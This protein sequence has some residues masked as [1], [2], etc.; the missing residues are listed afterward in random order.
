MSTTPTPVYAE[1]HQD[2]HPAARP[3]VT[4][5]NVGRWCLSEDECIADHIDFRSY[6][7]GV[8]DAARAFGNDRAALA[9]QA[10]SAAPV[11]P[12]GLRA[13]LKALEAL[14]ESLGSDYHTVEKT[15]Y[16]AGWTDAASF[17]KN[18][19]RA[20]I[21]DALHAE[22][23]RQNCETC[24]GTGEY[25]SH[26]EDCQDDLC[27]LNGDMHSCAGQVV[28]CDCAEEARRAT[29]PAAIP[30]APAEAVAMEVASMSWNGFNLHGDPKSI[31]KARQM[32]HDSEIVPELKERIRE[33]QDT[34]A[35][36]QAEPPA[37]PSAALQLL[38]K[39]RQ[40]DFLS[41]SSRG[42]I[43]AVLAAAPAAQ[44]PTPPVAQGP[45]DDERAE[46]RRSGLAAH[47]LTEADLAPPVAQQVEAPMGAELPLTCSRSNR[48][49]CALFDGGKRPSREWYA[50]KIQETEGLDNALPCGALATP[51]QAGAEAAGGGG[52]PKG[53]LEQA[54]AEVMR[55]AREAAIA[56]AAGKR[57]H[58][59]NW[60]EALAKVAEMEKALQEAKALA[61]SEG[62]RAVKYLRV[63]RKVRAV[64]NE[65]P[66]VD[67]PGSPLSRI[68]TIVAFAGGDSALGVGGRE[69][70]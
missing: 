51:A 23:A 37:D 47:G 52:T 41:D 40:D 19:I 61:D 57:T 65:W 63:V 56:V 1:T 67:I 48:S 46:A 58:P 54:E 13:T 3:T 17:C 50:A 55:C 21:A 49:D 11:E 24:G 20:V 29:P 26:A 32:L 39:I 7:L 60:Y 10:K 53:L 25:F 64:V 70:A 15:A 4:E 45:T 8:I 18:Q 12:A 38:R 14:I 44:Q 31:A 68:R 42:R 36:M 2:F 34:L 35:S 5:F 59:A 66:E 69:G 27:A 33:L 16:A 62:S 22:A 6:E 43:D 9:G 28:Q 30:E